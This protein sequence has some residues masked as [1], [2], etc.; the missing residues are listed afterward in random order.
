MPLVWA[1]LLLI[2]VLLPNALM[3]VVQSASRYYEEGLQTILSYSAV[4]TLYVLTV[5]LTIAF[6]II[7]SWWLS[8]YEISRMLSIPKLIEN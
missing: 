6:W 7:W 2:I 4:R 5:L 8:K 3:I 1:T